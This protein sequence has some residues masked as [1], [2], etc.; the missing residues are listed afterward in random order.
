MPGLPGRGAAAALSQVGA[1]R[2]ARLALGEPAVPRPSGAQGAEQSWGKST[3]TL[4]PNRPLLS[5]SP[6]SR[7]EPGLNLPRPLTS[8]RLLAQQI[9]PAKDDEAGGPI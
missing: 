9:C 5:R 6:A 7:V 3:Q 4:I 2:R 8:P 1:A